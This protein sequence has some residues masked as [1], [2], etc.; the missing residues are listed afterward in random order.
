MHFEWNTK[1]LPGNLVAQGLG[2]NDGHLLADA[3]VGVEVHGQSSVVLLDDN[4]GGLLDS[5]R[6][7]ATLH[8]KEHNHC[9]HQIPLQFRLAAS[10]SF[11][12][13]TK[14]TTTRVLLKLYC[15]H[16]R[17]V[18]YSLLS[19]SISRHRRSAPH[20][21]DMHHAKCSYSG[22]ASLGQPLGANSAPMMRDNSDFLQRISLTMLKI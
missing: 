21:H 9:R 5:L 2:R 16:L 20:F 7:N 8:K 11:N 14:T 10:F 3:L 18:V 6:T 22:G 15:W 12:A 1:H 4:L 19:L 17:T 13:P